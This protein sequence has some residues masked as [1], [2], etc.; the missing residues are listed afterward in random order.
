M[1]RIKPKKLSAFSALFALTLLITATIILLGDNLKSRQ[2]P[3]YIFLNELGMH[4]FDLALKQSLKLAEAE[5]EIENALIILNNLPPDKSIEEIANQYLEDFNIGARTGGKG[6]LFLYSYEEN[7]FRVAATDSLEDVLTDAICHRFQEAAKSYLTSQ[8]APHFL[9]GLIREANEQ[10][11]SGNLEK[12]DLSPPDWYAGRHL[13]SGTNVTVKAGPK[14][15]E[16]Y[17]RTLENLPVK[18]TE[19]FQPSRSP[20]ET[21]NR[22]V[23]S[24]QQFYGDPKLPLITTGSQFYRALAPRSAGQVRRAYEAY[25]N[26]LPFSLNVDGDLAVAVFRAGSSNLPLVLVK[27]KDGLWF[28]DE[29]KSGTYFRRYGEGTEFFPTFDDVPVQTALV[30]SKHPNAENPIYRKR[31]STPEPRNYPFSLKDTIAELKTKITVEP[32]RES[33]YVELGELYLFDMNW[34]TEAIRMFEK[35]AQLSPKKAELHWRLYD[36]YLTNAEIGKALGQI[37]QLAGLLPDDP[38]VRQWLDYYSIAY[39]FS[40]NEF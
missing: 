1:T 31:V 5:S 23:K 35:A 7:L 17:L 2:R 30:K 4:D 28:V 3:H 37:R 29:P 10:I 12:M 38:Q 13:S 22:Y 36:L 21:V 26:G 32:S 14:T 19:L 9:M 34:T 20:T 18:P 33:S 24:T 16:D 39:R 6:I 15:F 40:K 11:K 8:A 27:A 25:Q